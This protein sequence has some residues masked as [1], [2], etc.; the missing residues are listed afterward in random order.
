M[1]FYEQSPQSDSS[2]SKCWPY[3]ERKIFV[4]SN[5]VAALAYPREHHE[6]VSKPSIRPPVDDLYPKGNRK[7]DKFDTT[8]I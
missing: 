4:H 5:A 2:C 7:V 6:A 3:V 8:I 1:A